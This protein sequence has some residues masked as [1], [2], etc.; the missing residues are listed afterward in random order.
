[1]EEG[2]TGGFGAMVLHDFAA[3]GLLDAG[4]KIRTLVLPDFFIDHDSP[5]AQY[6]RS[7]L[8]A[9]GIV[10]TALAALGRPA[11]FATA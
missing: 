7:G 3:A 2:S 1:V 9:S 4:L 6:E 10:A 8:H 11:A 5:A